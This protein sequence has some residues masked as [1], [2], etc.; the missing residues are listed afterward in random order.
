MRSAF[1][2]NRPIYGHLQPARSATSGPRWTGPTTSHRSS[3]WN[4][5]S[6]WGGYL[7][8]NVTVAD[9]ITAVDHCLPAIEI[10]DSPGCENWRSPCRTPLAVGGSTGSGDPRW[11]APPARPAGRL[12]R[13]R[14][15]VLYDRVEVA[16]SSTSAIP[17]Q[18][19]V[20][21]RVRRKH[22]LR[23]RDR[24]PTPSVILAGSCLASRPDGEGRAVEPGTSPAQ[25]QRVEF[26][27]R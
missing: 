12:K 25:G 22:A 14:G 26:E 8:P 2:L 7:G 23:L 15:T 27:V 4:R 1:G 6:C 5:R 3:S 11:P 13:A 20:G 18:S 19:A 10:I 21:R 24:V 16:R 17:G 9:V